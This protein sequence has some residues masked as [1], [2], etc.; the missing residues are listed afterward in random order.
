MQ[1]TA[2][3]I[4]ALV[5][6]KLEICICRNCLGEFAAAVS[7]SNAFRGNRNKCIGDQIIAALFI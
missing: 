7:R 1:D 3:N 2:G 5:V 6:Y 4:F